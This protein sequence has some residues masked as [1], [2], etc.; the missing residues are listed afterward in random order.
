[1]LFLINLWNKN[2]AYLNLNEI[3]PEFELCLELDF[4]NTS[5]VLSQFLELL[6][7]I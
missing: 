2:T 7:G 4:P 5:P 3:M 1:M 6:Q